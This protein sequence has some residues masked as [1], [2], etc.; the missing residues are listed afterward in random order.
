MEMKKGRGGTVPQN[1]DVKIAGERAERV[2]HSPH[3]TTAAR[4][5]EVYGLICRRAP[6]VV[7]NGLMCFFLV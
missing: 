7:Q 2:N 3:M 4:G 5:C 6:E 1:T